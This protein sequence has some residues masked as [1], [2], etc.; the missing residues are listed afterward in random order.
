MAVD[1]GKPELGSR[2]NELLKKEEEMKLK[3]YNIQENL[4]Q[5]LGSAQG[6]ILGNKELINSLNQTKMSSEDVFK[7]LEE[8]KK[9]ELQ[10]EKEYQSYSPIA[11]FGSRLYFTI[12]SLSYINNIYQFSINSFKKV[13][14]K[15]LK[16]DFV[17]SENY[18]DIQEKNLVRDV[19]YHVSRSLFN[20]DRLAFAFRLF[21]NMFK[22][23][24]ILEV[25][26][27]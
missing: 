26:I 8:S 4:L 9:L 25:S 3:L 16:A 10:L 2:R 24:L 20:S 12:V 22:E 1:Q 13:F 6:D 21:S 11:E 5:Q 15:S 14:Q 7:S 23:S 27:F 18:I 19:Y 17:E